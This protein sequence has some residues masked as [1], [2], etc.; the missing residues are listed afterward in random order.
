MKISKKYTRILG[1][2][3]VIPLLTG[4]AA[5]SATAAY[6]LRAK[7]ADYLSAQGEQRITDRVKREVMLELGERE[8]ICV[9]PQY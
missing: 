4:C 6:A 3:L 2:I 1:T 5:G 9:Q 7:E 8:S